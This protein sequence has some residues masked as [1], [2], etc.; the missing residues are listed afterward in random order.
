MKNRID[1]DIKK[2]YCYLLSP[3]IV[4]TVLLCVYAAGGIYPFGSSNVEY[5][6]MAQGIIP[7]FY[8][9]WDALHNNDTALWFNWYSGLGVNDIANASLSVFWAV[10]LVIPRRLVGKAMS[11][12]VLMFFA[13]SS[14]S[15]CLFLRKA[16]N[17]R[18][19]MATLLS[20]CYA[21]CG[22]SVMYYTNAWQDTVFLFPLFMLAWLYMMKK[23]KILPYI[24]MIFINL[25]CGYYVFT[26]LI[27]YIFFMSWLYLKMC[28]DKD[29]RKR[30]A[31]E[32]G[33]ST[34]CGYGISAFFLLPKLV[35]TF[36]SERFID[37][38][39]FN[40][41]SL[42]TQYIEIAKT[43]EC[44][45]ADKWAMLF[46]T[47]LPLT[48]IILGIIKNR[49]AKKENGFFVLS[50]ALLAVL[51][52]C[53]GANALMHFGDYK[54]FPMRMGYALSFAFIWAAG[55][56]SKSLCLNKIDL[57]AGTAK[58]VISLIINTVF[59]IAIAGFV[60]LIM[61]KLDTSCE[62]QYA[63]LFAYPVIFIIYLLLLSRSNR[64]FDYRLSAA[65]LL[66]EVAMLS[67]LFIP[68][69]QTDMLD[70]EHNPAYISTSQSLVNKLDIDESKTE[71][72]K[73]VGT[74]LNC[75]YGTVMD[76]ATI[77]D[78]THLI[79]TQIQASLMSLGYSGEYTRLHDSG[80][81]AFTD[82]L[83]GVTNVLSVKEESSALY[84]QEGKAKGYYYY[85]CNYTLPYGIAVDKSI[86]NISA[87]DSNW[88]ELN[89]KLYSC[90][91]GDSEPLIT[92]SEMT[93]VSAEEKKETYK[94]K[95]TDGTTAYFR[96]RGARGVKIYV[97]G[98][99]ITIPSVDQK[100]NTKYPGRF[101]RDLISLGEFGNS[102]IEIT[103]EFTSGK[104][105]DKADFRKN[106]YGEDDERNQNFLCEVG[107]LNLSKLEN[108]CQ[109]YSSTNV[110]AKN[111]SLNTEINSDSVDKVLLLPLQYNGCWNASVNGNDKEVK[112]V[113]N[114]LT[115]VELDKGINNVDMKFIP[116]GFDAGIIITAAFILIL[117]LALILGQKKKY[118]SGTVCTAVSAV[119]DIFF[120][121]ALIL[122]YIIPIVLL[123]YQFI[124]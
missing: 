108:V 121:A 14:M 5:Y 65:S 7:N 44:K 78:W 109:M 17:T 37:E 74:T 87:E 50:I 38:T 118:A 113:L 85:S 107:L 75:N 46:C 110:I 122:I 52:V 82:A 30:R 73:T 104:F 103:L 81:T 62:F 45:S 119:Y 98:E 20:V 12:Y 21:F 22:F 57:K 18:P 58:K 102:E 10:L 70:K 115:A 92:E 9:I 79:P 114:L 71:R 24:L 94:F 34:I 32:L 28:V 106:D 100:K 123:V 96:L 31:F 116:A 29:I 64:L 83:L 80:G 4:G 35:Q 27:L 11:L 84:T 47:A 67:M 49:K 43:T 41:S 6:D 1:F 51:I 42:V 16:E 2:N 56:Y 124:T 101:N 86:L 23:G 99:K 36:S 53:E 33:F 63:C 120:A 3:I 61:K 25:L 15:A 13:L 77:S 93:L 89:N 117:L 95:S 39:G 60:Y 111:Y 72:I 112:P 91:S 40:F 69:R 90:I 88:R 48:I 105:E 97:N 76:H 54:Y 68:Y 8:H 55:H 66:A 26:L 19:F 59:F